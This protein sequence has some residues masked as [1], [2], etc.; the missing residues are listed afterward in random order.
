VVRTYPRSALAVTITGLFD[1]HMYFYNT[2]L[3]LGSMR[4]ADS[5]LSTRTSYTLGVMLDEIILIIF[6]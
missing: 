4:E 5:A 6:K 1:G 3:V 2:Q